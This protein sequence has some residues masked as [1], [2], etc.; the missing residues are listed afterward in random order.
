MR[1]FGLSFLFISLV[2]FMSGCGVPQEEHD[3]KI[4]QL[5]TNHTNDVIALKADI[6]ELDEVV[7]SEKT[8][9]KAH[10]IEIDSADR[11]LK[12]LQKKNAESIKELASAKTD[13]TSLKRRLEREEDAK[14]RAQ[15]DARSLKNQLNQALSDRDEVQKRYDQLI[16]NLNGEQQESI[17][18]SIDNDAVDSFMSEFSEIESVITEDEDLSLPEKNQVL[19]E[20]M[21]SSLPAVD[22]NQNEAPSA[23]E[24]L[25]EK[26]TT[27]VTEPITPEEEP[28]NDKFLGIFPKFRLW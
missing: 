28:K 24:V 10:R 4:K 18:Q 21:K 14:D 12:E 27:A 8:K 2:I 19:L 6:S 15:A 23:L 9:A 22:L 5:L 17:D 26:T 7:K 11:K 1:N 16:D 13:I 25:Q 20:E 3:A